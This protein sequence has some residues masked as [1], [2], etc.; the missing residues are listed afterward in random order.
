M[1]GRIDLPYLHLCLWSLFFVVRH[2]GW[3][4]YLCYVF[5]T[6]PPEGW[7]GGVG[8]VSKEIIQTHCPAPAPDVQVYS[9][10]VCLVHRFERKSL[11]KILSFVRENTVTKRFEQ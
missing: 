1:S 4:A 3:N 7:N 5:F 6:Q 9:L 8:F 11:N 2:L 10:L